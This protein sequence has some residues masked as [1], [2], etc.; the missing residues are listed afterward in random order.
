MFTRLS[1]VK[2]APLLVVYENQRHS[3]NV[4]VEDI[5]PENFSA[6]QLLSGSL[7]EPNSWSDCGGESRNPSAWRPQETAD[8]GDQES[9]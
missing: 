4:R 2:P 7:G 6:A 9:A 3:S 1:R 8:F 5:E